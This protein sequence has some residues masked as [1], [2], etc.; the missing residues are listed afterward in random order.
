MNYEINTRD[1]LLSQSK[2]KV[3]QLIKEQ[4][5]KQ[6]QLRQARNLR[7]LSIAVLSLTLF[8]LILIVNQYITKK[9]NTK[10]LE[11]KNRILTESEYKLD[12][13]NKTKDKFFSIIAHDLKNP[14]GGLVS[15]TEL[16]NKQYDD[17]DDESR[18]EMHQIMYTSAHQLNT[19]LE[20]LLNWSRA[21]L[22][23]MPYRPE[24]IDINEVI[25]SCFS[26]QKI[27][28]NQKSITL[29]NLIP[30]KTMV[31][32]D[33]DMLSLLIR[34]LVSNA[35]KFTPE[36]GN[37]TIKQT[38]EFPTTI[39]VCDTGVGMSQ[40]DM[41]KLFRL[42]VKFSTTG[43]QNEPGTGLGLILCKECVERMNGTI[44]V[45]STLGKGSCFI[46]TLPN[47]I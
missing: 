3:N 17:L 42:D 9:K 7:N 46:F 35:L 16:I 12:Q 11:E 20:N 27:N 10:L 40:E 43:T 19:L 14:L 1:S 2:Q 41:A 24:V 23:K 31:W 29:E 22:G 5:T 44:R 34:N 38:S 30:A 32:A 28:A 33:A 18:K 21:Q 47:K 36:G 37:I 4:E 13:I 45:N 6:I 39:A 26:L 25:H 8:A 15:L